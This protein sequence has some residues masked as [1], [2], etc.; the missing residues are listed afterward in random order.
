MLEADRA[1][2]LRDVLRLGVG[3]EV[4]LF[5]GAGATAP[6]V[7]QAVTR[8]KVTLAI[9]P[10]QHHPPRTSGR[11]VLAASIAKGAR[12]DAIVTG[13]TELGVDHIA[14]V[15]F[16]RTVK[17]AAGRAGQA[18]REKLAIAAA[19][20]CGRIFL[21]RLTGPHD[22][23]ETVAALQAE[24]SQAR[25]LFGGFS[26]QAHPLANNRGADR[27]VIAFVGP[28][29]GWV[30]SEQN[31][32]RQVGAVEVSITRT[33]LRIETAALALAS[34]LCMVRDGRLETG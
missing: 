31:A 6:G 5:D 12:F 3:S 32:L 4:E 13:C 14:A 19:Q 8:Q 23:H 33:T 9:G 29:G 7:V 22:F 24:Y 25:W 18:R 15:R 11:I 30:E 17:Q 28:E 20:Q 2:H 21:P 1:H 34:V 27:D 26:S 16:E 10:V